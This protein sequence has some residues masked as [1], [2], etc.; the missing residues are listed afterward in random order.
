MPLFL[1]DGTCNLFLTNLKRSVSVTQKRQ[2]NIWI[3]D[4][5]T[6]AILSKEEIWICQII[7]VIREFRQISFG[8]KKIEVVLSSEVLRGKM[9]QRA[10]GELRR[11]SEHDE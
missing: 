11:C 6:G 8:T 4:I 3:E 9:R 10:S 5:L 1:L 2:V 7:N